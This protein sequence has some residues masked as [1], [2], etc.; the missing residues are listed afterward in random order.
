MARPYKVI[1][2]T[3]SV[4][5]KTDN[6]CRHALPALL[7]RFRQRSKKTL[8]RVWSNRLRKRFA[9]IT[10]PYLQKRKTRRKRPRTLRRKRPRTRRRKRN[11]TRRRKRKR[12]RR[13]KRRRKR[14][15][16]S[17]K[18]TRICERTRPRKKFSKHKKDMTC[19]KTFFSFMS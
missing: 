15:R 3:R 11:R 14:P 5:Q 4:S 8:R 12:T 7:R 9:L 2:A 6:K 10:R 18:R 17:A 19:H 1:L 16:I 13:R